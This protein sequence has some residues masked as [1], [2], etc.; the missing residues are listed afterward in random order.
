M[1]KITNMN[2]YIAIPVDEYIALK[3]AAKKATETK[4]VTKAKSKIKT[5]EKEV[6]FRA[7]VVTKHEKR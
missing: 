4:T 5:D 1:K 6:E 3:E 2:G 7:A